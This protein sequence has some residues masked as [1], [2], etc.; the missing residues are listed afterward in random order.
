MEQTVES[1]IRHYVEVYKQIREHGLTED[2]ALAIVENIGKDGRVEKMRGN[3]Q[4]AEPIS[5]GEQSATQKQLSF[6]KRLHVDV[7]EGLTKQEASRLIDEAQT[8]VIAA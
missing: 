5:N 4:D 7:P 1:R 6:L 8:K 3:E 2:I